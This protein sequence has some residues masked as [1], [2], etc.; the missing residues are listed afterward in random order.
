MVF[1]EIVSRKFSGGI[2]RMADVIAEVIV[3]TSL[4]GNLIGGEDWCGHRL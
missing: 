1:L 3:L 4:L 2:R